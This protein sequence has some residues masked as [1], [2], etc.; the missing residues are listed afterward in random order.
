[1]KKA[2]RYFSPFEWGLIALSYAA[3]LITFFLFDGENYLNLVSTLVGIASLVFSAKG[4]PMGPL[5]MILFAS[6]YGVISFTFS[7]YGE[8]ITYLG[9]SLPMSV[10]AFI[11]WFRNPSGRGHAETA[12]GGIRGR[13]WLF[14]GALTLA[15]TVAFYFILG[16][17]DTPNLI[18]STLSVSTSFAA[19]YLTARRSPYFAL[20]YAT[21]DVVLILLWVLAT[22]KDIGYLSV[23]ACFGVFL[24]NDLYS[25]FNC[26][27]MSKRQNA[28]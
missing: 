28:K 27:R 3:I 5:L 13:E 26:R 11:A 7:Y 25:F 6:A 21:N 19:C 2:L 22:V 17:L 9:M 14:L 12:V 18:P 4:N 24:I 15:V 10:W 8:M 23:T 16:A 20:A 1:M